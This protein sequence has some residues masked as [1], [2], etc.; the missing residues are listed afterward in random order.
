MRYK[1]AIYCHTLYAG[2]ILW[3]FTAAGC[4][5]KI[6]TPTSIDNFD[7]LM[8]DI[9]LLV[10]SSY[11]GHF[12]RPMLSHIGSRN[13]PKYKYA[14]WDTE[15][16]GLYNVQMTGFELSK[17]DMIFSICPEMLEKLKSRNIP[18][19]RLDFA[20]NPTIHYPKSTNANEN[21]TISLVGNAWLGYA[22]YHPAHFRYSI[23][24]PIIL[25]PLIENNYKIDFYGTYEYKPAIKRFLNLE[26][27]IEWFKGTIPYEKTCDIYCSSY[28]NLI[29]QNH[30]QTITRRTFEILASGG[31]GLSCN[32][33]AIK[34][35]FGTSG[36]LAI[37][38]SS[39]ET[40]DVLEYYN[41]NMDAYTKV[42]ENAVICV[43]N[44][45]YKER[46]EV[47]INKIFG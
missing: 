9:D 33:T 13:S 35:M 15:G 46:A 19:E 28:I 45:T 7:K 10:L 6:I 16:V 3:G 31:F 21:K 24:M 18:C 47:I 22:N 5:S 1:V 44:N 30:E 2:D 4:E 34:N 37:S 40:L 41:K 20:Y 11:M 38:N 26:V 29:T 25:K 12:S 8:E 27:P 23:A 17:P 32:N 39:N 43:Q 42:R 36:G 14:C